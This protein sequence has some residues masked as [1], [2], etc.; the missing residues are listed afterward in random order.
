MIFENGE[1]DDGI[2]D[3]SESFGEATA[4]ASVDGKIFFVAQGFVAE[5]AKAIRV[6]GDAKP[7][8]FQVFVEAV[9]D[10]DVFGGNAGVLKALADELDEEDVGGNAAASQAVDLEPNY[11]AG[12]EQ[13]FPRI[14]GRSGDEESLHGAI[15][16]VQE[17][18]GIQAG[19]RTAKEGIARDH[20]F[21]FFLRG[22]ERSEDRSSTREQG[23]CGTRFEEI[24]AVWW[25][26]VAHGGPRRVRR[27]HRAL[28]IHSYHFALLEAKVNEREGAK[29]AQIERKR[30][31][32]S[33]RKAGRK[34]GF[35]MTRRGELGVQWLC[36]GVVDG[37]FGRIPQ[38]K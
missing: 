2:A 27:A 33:S 29:K 1:I 11:F 5:T 20:D 31:R 14:Q 7:G 30:E 12:T 32:G 9:P 26:P 3:L 36:F 22:E 37:N 13:L 18:S 8:A 34:C 35:R 10:D 4:D 23:A 25:Q 15:E 17:A 28:L 6:S 16:H 38:G 24:P 21:G 19:T